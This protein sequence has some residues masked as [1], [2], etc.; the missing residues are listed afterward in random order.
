[1]ATI[2]CRG[3]Y[4]TYPGGSEPVFTDLDLILR[5][6]ARTALGGRN[7]RGK[8]TLLRLL[9]GMLQP[10]RGSIEG[11]SQVCL[12]E[13]QPAAGERTAWE[14]AKDS[15]GPYRRWEA[16]METALAT[17]SDAALAEYADLQQRYAEADGYRVEARL[18]ELL[19][20]LELPEQHWHRPLAQLSGGEATRAAL[21]GLFASGQRYPLIDE[22]TNHL[23]RRGR[24]RLADFLTRRAGF[25]LVSHDRTFVDQCTEQTLVLNQDDVQLNQGSFSDWR[26]RHQRKLQAQAERNTQLRREA[27]RLNDA[28]DARRAGAHAREAAKSGAVDKGFEGARAARQMKR[29]LAA[30]QRARS[31]AQGRRDA[32]HNVEKHYPLRLAAH[33]HDPAPLEAH[34]LIVHRPAPLFAPLSFSLQPGDRL[35]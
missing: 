25:L 9:A 30:E 14:T 15:A 4:F 21:A 7:G 10:D 26:A 22:P 31:A 1:M 6:S 18:A 8:T 27:Q 17:S 23:D 28:A 19:K 20:E 12:F 16:A 13:P 32:M 2:I 3:V 5:R 34:D 29:A 35:V 24:A 11:H 33:E